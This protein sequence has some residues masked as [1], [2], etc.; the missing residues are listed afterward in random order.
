MSSFVH[1]KVV[2][3]E[4]LGAVPHI[5]TI[6]VAFKNRDLLNQAFTDFLSPGDTLLFPNK[7][8]F[9]VGGVVGDNLK[10]LVIQIDGTLLFSD[11]RET[12]PVDSSGHVLECIYLTNLQ[13]IKFTSSGE[14]TLDG[15]GKK[16][17]GAID[18][19]KHQV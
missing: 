6:D 10:D 13:N 9:M 14:G 1:S 16:W 8:F 2:D 11:D 4:R 5:Q 3:F 12:W 19:L 17:W 7:T 18:F 15:N